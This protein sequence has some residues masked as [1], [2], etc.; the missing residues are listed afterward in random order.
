VKRLVFDLPLALHPWA[1]AEG[2]PLLDDLL[3]AAGQGNEPSVE[4]AGPG[5]VPAPLRLVAPDPQAVYRISPALPVEAQQ[6]RLEAVAGASVS[7]ITLWMDGL[8]LA[9]PLDPPFEAWWTLAPG[10][11]QAWAQGWDATGRQIS[12]EPVLF[13]VLDVA[14]ERELP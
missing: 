11:H 3:L 8:Q 10:Q 5:H 4:A 9:A 2:L 6:V 14:K 7:Q 1:R 12:S 13:E